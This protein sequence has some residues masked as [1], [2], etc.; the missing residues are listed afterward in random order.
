[1]NQASMR[2]LGW[3]GA[4]VLLTASLSSAAMVDRVIAR[5]GGSGLEW[6]VSYTGAGGVLGGGGESG[7]YSFGPNGATPMLGD[8]NNDGI[9]DLVVVYSENEE[10]KWQVAYTGSNGALG[11]GGLSNVYGFGST[12]YTP[13]LGDFNGDGRKDLVLTKTEGSTLQW[14][15]AFTGTNGVLGGGGGTGWMAFGSASDT[16]LIGDYDGNGYSDRMLVRYEGAMRWL[17]SYTP[18]LG[19]Q[20]WVNFGSNGD[21]PVVGDFNGDGLADL[22]LYRY[23]GSARKYIA[24]LTDPTL[25]IGGGAALDWFSFGALTDI[26]LTPADLNGDGRD[27]LGLIRVEGNVYYWLAAFTGESGFG[28]SFSEWSPFGS[29]GDTPL[30]GTMLPEPTTLGLLLC[31]GLVILRRNRK[32][33][34]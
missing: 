11:G 32:H 26:P 8:F 6:I 34:S 21:S 14:I 19:E 2:I 4:V 25:G 13:R 23:D 24:L 16:G 22:S 31:G 9:D 3:L 7:W 29:T 30:T 33:N 27:D 1:M 17:V 20:G 28:E 18:S 5:P 12:Q 10:W 15:A